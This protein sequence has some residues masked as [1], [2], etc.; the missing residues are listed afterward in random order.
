MDDWR[1]S[2]GRLSVIP[3]FSMSLY[4]F[5][6]FRRRGTSRQ[7]LNTW[8]GP[9][10]WNADIDL[11]LVIGLPAEC[12]SVVASVTSRSITSVNKINLAVANRSRV[13]SEHKVATVNFQ[14]WKFFMGEKACGAQ[15]VATAATSIIS[16]RGSFCCAMLCKRGLCRHAVSVYLCVY[17]SV[18]FLNSVETNKHIIKIFSPSGSHTI[19]VFPCQTA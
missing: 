17:V 2:V 12:Q 11:Y 9:Q 1:A 5:A 3:T 13:S 8:P 6:V 10:L 7:S 15:M 16:L 18:S 19:L 4:L 14:R